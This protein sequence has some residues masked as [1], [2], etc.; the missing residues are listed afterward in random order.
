[1]SYFIC[2]TNNKKGYQARRKSYNFKNMVYA[3]K[4]LSLAVKMEQPK[5]N[6]HWNLPTQSLWRAVGAG[7]TLHNEVPGRLYL[8]SLTDRARKP[9]SES[10]R[11]NVRTLTPNRL[12]MSTTLK[13]HSNRN[14]TWSL[15]IRYLGRPRSPRKIFWRYRTF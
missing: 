13:Q 2:K 6:V 11:S 7:I 12:A 14:S 10:R 1:M 5:S 4:R 3:E 8:N 9:N 15:D